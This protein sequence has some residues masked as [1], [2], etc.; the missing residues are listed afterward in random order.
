MRWKIFGLMMQ[1]L[2]YQIADSIDIRSFRTFFKAQLVH[3]DTDELLKPCLYNMYTC[4]NMAWFAFWTTPETW[5]DENLSK[6]DIGLKRIF[7]LRER[8]RNIQEGLEIVK[9]NLELFKD[10]MQSGTATS[11]NGSLSS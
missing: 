11:S 9:E 8:F 1:V 2:S 3:Y 7:D 4:L 6:I 10:I 5:E